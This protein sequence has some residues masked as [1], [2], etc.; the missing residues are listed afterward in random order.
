MRDDWR[1]PHG[2]LSACLLLAVAMTAP[3]PAF[4]WGDEGHE[5]IALIAEHYLDRRCQDNELVGQGSRR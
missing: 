1:F 3:C 4:G 5:I 2:L